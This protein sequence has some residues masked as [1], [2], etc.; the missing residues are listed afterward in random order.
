MLQPSPTNIV[1]IESRSG[2]RSGSLR[3]VGTGLLLV[4]ALTAT[5]SALASYARYREARTT[6]ATA[7]I[8]AVIE[9][10][11]LSPE[12]LEVL[13]APLLMG[14]PQQDANSALLITLVSASGVPLVGPRISAMV[15][16]GERFGSS[17][18]RVQYDNRPEEQA[19][20]GFVSLADGRRLF[21]GHRLSP[22]RDRIYPELRAIIGA[23]LITGLALLAYGVRAKRRTDRQLAAVAVALESISN[24]DFTQVLPENVHG[25][26]WDRLR[27]HVNAA[28]RRLQSLVEQLGSLADLVSHELG[29]AVGRV[30]ARLEKVTTAGDA[31]EAQSAAQAALDE[32]MRARGAMQSLLNLNSIKS[33][34]A[35]RFERVDLHAIAR[36]VV[37]MFATTA[38]DAGL[39]LAAELT[40]AHVLGDRD[41]LAQ[42]LANLI[43]NA[44]KYTPAGGSVDVRVTCDG[45][46]VTFSVCDTGPGIPREHRGTMLQPARRLKRDR[47]KPGYGYGLAM[48]YAVARR[49]GGDV[50]MPDSPHGLRVE[51]I[52][53]RYGGGSD[54]SPSSSRETSR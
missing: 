10:R 26:E 41:L 28:S 38:E 44:I 11:A 47:D 31:A 48:V 8:N 17:A 2:W 39:Q 42:L 50:R 43:D 36:A 24:G 20:G 13:I 1:R 52:F 49:H 27:G 33:G 23:G 7:G 34:G 12:G 4:F 54:D 19:Y 3:H 18:Y 25:D 30:Q 21:I 22:Y 9:A 5:L 15:P 53:P 32:T 37:Q 46:H 29:S 14:H 51:A 35:Y 40:P 45:D 6:A 16:A